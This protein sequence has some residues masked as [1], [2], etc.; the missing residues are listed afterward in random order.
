MKDE[1]R[2]VTSVTGSWDTVN[3]PMDTSMEHNEA[4]LWVVEADD[5]VINSKLVSA[6]VHGK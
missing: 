4:G 3:L 2:P 1:L 5:P 6:I